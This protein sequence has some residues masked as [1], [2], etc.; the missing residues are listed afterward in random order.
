M[1]N[2]TSFIYNWNI[3]KRK[4]KENCL[5][6]AICIQK[7]N[8]SKIIDPL[9]WSIQDILTT[10]FSRSFSLTRGCRS[11]PPQKERT[12]EK[13]SFFRPPYQRGF[14]DQ[15]GKRVVHTKWF[16]DWVEVRGRSG[17]GWKQ[18][19][20]GV[21]GI[22]GRL[23]QRG[24]KSRYGKRHMIEPNKKMNYIQISILSYLI[25]STENEKEFIVYPGSF[26]K[27][28]ALYTKSGTLNLIPRSL[29][30]CRTVRR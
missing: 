28:H 19:S 17:E 1:L 22:G 23:L 29:R 16:V 27:F 3:K 6:K 8:I 2:W 12:R 5:P 25:S 14:L 21:V 26:I 11:N 15:S 4:I 9:R 18:A 13:K 24:P 10:Q 30:P 7:I 20:R